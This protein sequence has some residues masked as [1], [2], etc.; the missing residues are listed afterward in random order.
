M[1]LQTMV[2]RTSKEKMNQ[3][4]KF[5]QAI[6]ESV[7]DYALLYRLPDSAQSF[8]GASSLRF[9]RKNPFDFFLF[10]TARHFLYAL[11]MKTV[12]G[13]SISF[14]RDKME[15]GEIHYH[16]I[17]GLEEYDKYEN[18][19]CGFIIEFRELEKTV[20]LDIKSF[21]ELINKINKKSFS[22]SDLESSELPFFV[23]PQTKKRTKYTYDMDMFLKSNQKTVLFKRG[24]R[25]DNCVEE[26]ND[27]KPEGF[28]NLDDIKE[29]V[30]DI[31]FQ[32]AYNDAVNHFEYDG[33]L[34]F[35]AAYMTAHDMVNQRTYSWGELTNIISDTI[36]KVT[37]YAKNLASEEN[38]K[39][40]QELSRGIS[41]GGITADA[42]VEAYGKTIAVDASDK[43]DSKE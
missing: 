1:D 40:L 5:E 3:G 12:K 9:S 29:F 22:Y 19:I 34:S 2:G 26:W 15:H 38:I 6:R 33:E 27:E 28:D 17:K 14:E 10:D 20:F 13:K 21:N 39:L 31:D 7:P 4:K 36:Q 43:A 24:K 16:Q 42:I 18:V 30:N 37:D 8:G 25:D 11:E 41:D 32:K 23:I 35:S